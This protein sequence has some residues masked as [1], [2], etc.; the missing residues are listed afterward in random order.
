M[1]RTTFFSLP[2]TGA[3]NNNSCDVAAALR[4]FSP[5]SVTVAPL[6]T[7]AKPQAD[8]DTGYVLMKAIRDDSERAAMDEGQAMLPGM[9][10]G[11]GRDAGD[12][13][14]K[15]TSDP[16]DPGEGGAAMAAVDAA[17]RAAIEQGKTAEDYDAVATDLLGAA[18]RF[19]DEPEMAAI[20]E[21][22][23]RRSGGKGWIHEIPE[24]VRE[25][26]TKIQP[27]PAAQ[28]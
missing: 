2:G 12:E 23:N 11:A 18:I 26:W 10:A 5:R 1:S 7:R 4:G 24:I 20:I 25:R 21:E 3:V 8:I 22:G 19:R 14:Q 16:S 9:D 17:I 27:A 15:A 28:P 6:P 13:E